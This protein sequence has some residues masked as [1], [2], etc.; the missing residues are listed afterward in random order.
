MGTHE[1]LGGMRG[2]VKNG[3]SSEEGGSKEFRGGGAA[4]SGMDSNGLGGELVRGM[5]GGMGGKGGMGGDDGGRADGGGEEAVVLLQQPC[6]VCFEEPMLGDKS[7]PPVVMVALQPCGHVLCAQ[8]A[9]Q[10]R[11]LVCVRVC[12][13]MCVRVCPCVNMFE[14]TEVFVFLWA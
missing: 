9:L 5:E 10:V 13:C 14:C 6:G 1:G 4:M 2:G 11:V 3:L 12:V 7:V 8:C